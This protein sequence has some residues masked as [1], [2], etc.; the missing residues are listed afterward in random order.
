MCSLARLRR[1]DD[2]SSLL[3]DKKRAR[4]DKAFSVHMLEYR[5][6]TRTMV[7]FYL[8][9]S[10]AVKLYPALA[11]MRQYMA[12]SKFIVHLPSIVHI[13]YT[14]TPI[15]FLPH[16]ADRILSA[17]DLPCWDGIEPGMIAAKTETVPLFGQ[18]YLAVSKGHPFGAFTLWLCCYITAV[19]QVAR[20]TTS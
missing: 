12:T 2:N 3:P 7:H 13:W 6:Y 9:M 10:G 16:S 5:V 15:G 11:L 19:G 17:M 8:I 18:L 14:C 1:R 4:L 20:E